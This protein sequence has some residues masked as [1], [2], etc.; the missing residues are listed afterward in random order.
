MARLKAVLFDN[1]GTLVDSY[2]LLM[3]CFRFATREVLGEPLPDEVIREKIGQPLAVQVLDFTDDPEKQQGIVDAYR[4]RNAVVHD[5]MIAPFPDTCASLARL[6]DEGFLMGVV[7]AK[8]HETA[9]HGLEVVG[10][11]PYLSCLVGADDCTPNKPDGAP[12]R[13]ACQIL[14]VA[15]ADCAYVGDSPY[16]AMSAN[17]AGCISIAVTWGMFPEERLRAAEPTYVCDSY[18]QLVDLLI[19][20]KG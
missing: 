9:W 20:L 4:A 6:H 10:A 1:D 11:A 18:P 2:E 3:E 7:T 13:M 15:P 19:G 5:Q 12:V 14:G 8:R 17:D 16:D